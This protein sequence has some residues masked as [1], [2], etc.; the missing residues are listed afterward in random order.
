MA[1]GLCRLL[2][3]RLPP[4]QTP[5]PSD[6]DALTRMLMDFHCKEHKDR[7]GSSKFEV[8]CQLLHQVGKQVR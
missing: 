5:A 3:W 7:M 2:R 6:E 8:R 4:G 1:I